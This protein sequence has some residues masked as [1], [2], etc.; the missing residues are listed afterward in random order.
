MHV[1]ASVRSFAGACAVVTALGVLAS[2][3]RASA[4]SPMPTQDANRLGTGGGQGGQPPPPCHPNRNAA[5]DRE[6]VLNRED[7]RH[8]P[9]PLRDRLSELAV[10][11]HSVLPVEAFAEAD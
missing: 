2:P 6:T 1:R 10:R 3:P 5:R 9:G 7:V 11:P 4:A 8:L